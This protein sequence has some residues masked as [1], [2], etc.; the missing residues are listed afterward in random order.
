MPTATSSDG[1][2]INYLKS[3]SGPAL[4]LVDGA[5]C[6][7]AFGPA[8]SLTKVLSSR[9]TV[10]TYDR[11]GRGASGPIDPDYDTLRE[12]EDL[13][14][15]LAAAGDGAYLFGQSSGSVLVL[16]AANRLPGIAKIATYEAPFI[17][18]D[19]TNPRPAGLV[20]QMKRL[21]QA[22]QGSAAVKLFMR[23][24][25]APAPVI[26]IMSLTP[27]WKKMT[28]T[29]PTLPYDL[30]LVQQYGDGNPI[31]AGR[32]SRATMPALVMAGAKSPAWMQHAQAA[33]A[34]N[35]PVAT[36]RT[37]PGQTHM[38]KADALAPALY[39]FLLDEAVQPEAAPK[40]EA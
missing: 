12:V 33:I 21:V 1:T 5:M 8:E 36:Y 4:V 27:V 38:L 17:V 10:Y 15:V 14:A 37:L 13:A 24:V 22:G 3:G 19:A 35:L 39:E 28:A 6:S 26:F 31:P 7:T 34:H 18:D 23:T 20:D 32:W 16:E 30:T 40:V 9:F 29:A 2:K 11:R 25:Q